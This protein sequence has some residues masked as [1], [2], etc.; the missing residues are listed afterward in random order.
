MN[1]AALELFNMIFQNGLSEKE[2]RERERSPSAVL[3]ALSAR[4]SSAEFLRSFN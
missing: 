2:H 1:S 4:Y 3:F